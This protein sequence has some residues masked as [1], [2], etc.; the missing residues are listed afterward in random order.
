[1]EKFSSQRG[2]P[3][4]GLSIV[5]TDVFRNTQLMITRFVELNLY[6]G[7]RAIEAFPTGYMAG[8]LRAQH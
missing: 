5:A 6:R 7:R 3:C 8:Q 2:G 4:R 1:M